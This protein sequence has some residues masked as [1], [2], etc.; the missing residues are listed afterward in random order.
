MVLFSFVSHIFKLKK[1]SLTLSSPHDVF[2]NNR[3]KETIFKCMQMKNVYCVEVKAVVVTRFRNMYFT[4]K[5]KCYSFAHSN[6]NND[7]L[8]ENLR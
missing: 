6:N 8:N 3:T 4:V 5:D 2:K 7:L 1:L